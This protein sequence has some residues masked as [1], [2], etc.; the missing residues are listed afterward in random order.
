M[1]SAIADALPGSEPAS[2]IPSGV[3]ADAR[4]RMANTED[5]S[6]QP[7]VADL[8]PFVDF[9]E[10]L[11]LL[12][13][14]KSSLGESL[15]SQLRDWGQHLEALIPIR[16]RVAHSRPLE[17]GDLPTV[18]DLVRNLARNLLC[19][20]NSAETLARIASNPSSVLDLDI[21]FRNVDPEVRRHNLPLPD[22]DE[23]GLVGRAT[24]EK[25]LRGMLRGPYPVISLVGDGG[26]GKTALAL[27]VAYSMLDEP[28]RAFD[29]IVWTSAKAAQLTQG[30]VTRIE[31][32]IKDSLGMLD[33]AARQLAGDID[34]EDPLAEVLAYMRE[35][36]VLLILDNLET[37]LDAR[38]REFL[39]QLPNDS[40]VLIT[41]RIGLGSLELPLKLDALETSDAVVLLRATARSRGLTLISKGDQGVLEKFSQ[42]MHNHPLYIKWFVSVVQAGKR[43]E[44]VLANSGDFL[45]FCMSNVYEFLEPDSLTALRC[46]QALPGRQSQATIAEV[47]LLPVDS[48]QTALAQL[49]TTNFV[50]L[51]PTA[52]GGAISSEYEITEFAQ[53]YLDRQHPLGNAV[54]M[55]MSWRYKKL[56]EQGV[57]LASASVAD[58][59]SERSL[60]VGGPADFSVA[61][62]LHNAMGLNDRGQSG[63]AL[64][65]VAEAQMLAPDY[66]ETYRVE[67]M[68]FDRIG[69][70]G[71]AADAYERALEHA[72]GNER[73]LYH[74]GRF[75]MRRAG[76][77][78]RGLSLLQEA[79]R[80]R[81][82]DPVLQL[83]IV[84][85]H[86]RCGDLRQALDG[87]TGLI[88][89]E[90][91][92]ISRVATDL[93]FKSALELASNHFEASE[94]YEALEHIETIVETVLPALLRTD[95]LYQIRRVQVR[96]LADRY[97]GK[98]TERYL[99]DALTRLL[100]LLGDEEGHPG[101][102]LFATVAR[103]VPERGFGFLHLQGR[104]DM[105]FGSRAVK[106]PGGFESL[107]VGDEVCFV[108]GRDR[109]GRLCAE[110]VMDINGI[111][112]SGDD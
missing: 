83:E 77:P 56:L 17:V 76:D 20:A 35:F 36:R 65:L 78:V 4:R 10:A 99:S 39:S 22:F 94:H 66:F 24:V 26:L 98:L 49:I 85:G 7:S 80:S 29:A 63:Q 47:T 101:A 71:R 60:I 110:Q 9:G 61:M 89:S 41:S 105:F 33:A 91:P 103:I 72:A 104:A 38:L 95:E 31:G 40:K 1:R 68:L 112:D 90:N 37:V 75:F 8:L 45:D 97:A 13:R 43:P 102:V 88:S 5:S 58:P 73:C 67:A 18:E 86:H 55:D 100:G 21:V 108:E 6:S 25:K 42:R 96:N 27:K 3:L 84:R 12:N 74:A 62:K 15:R 2:V 69:D 28:T 92:K 59:Y 57:R 23:T 19:W 109:S 14:H 79:A 34:L 44:D 54:R 32:A 30:E 93:S 51:Q 81:R 87:A 82:D 106:S 107:S 52:R 46:L 11:A 50:N 48:L 70:I 111:G 16:N 64:E 53:K